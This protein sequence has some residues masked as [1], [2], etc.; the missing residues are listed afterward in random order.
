MSTGS[1]T[2]EQALP[3]LAAAHEAGK[4]VPFVGAGMSME[5][6]KG[7][8][9][10]VEALAAELKLPLPAAKDGQQAISPEDLYRTAD[11][12]ASHL[13]LMSWSARR[14]ILS[15]ALRCTGNTIPKQMAALTGLDWPLI[16]TTNYDDLI[17]KSRPNQHGV[18]EPMVLGRSRK[19][20]VDVVRSLDGLQ[21]PIVWHVQGHIARMA[22]PDAE[23]LSPELLELLEQVVLG[24][25]EYQQA[26][27]AE[28]DFRRAFAEVFRRRSLL[29]LGSGLAE[30]YMV[31]LISEAM[32]GMG[33]SPHPHYAMMTSAEAAK[34]DPAFLAVRLGI[35]P[36]VYGE[37]HGE[38]PE[39]IR[40]LVTDAAAR[41][42]TLGSAQEAPLPP[43][44][45][46]MAFVLDHVDGGQ[47]EVWLHRGG[48]PAAVVMPGQC[49]IL[50]LGLDRAQTGGLFTRIAF[51]NQVRAFKANNEAFGD[52]AQSD[53]V[54][55][56]QQA[57]VGQAPHRLFQLRREGLLKPIF[58]ASTTV[59]CYPAWK[60]DPV[61]GV[62]GVQK[63]PL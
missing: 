43:G 45:R 59:A 20:C 12:A 28:P 6:C 46:S 29:F 62:I 14:R 55:I 54:G 21:R 30:S 8:R 9:P 44:L 16:V 41:K 57:Q 58:G 11:R 4:L 52:I 26:I 51:G 37:N 32:H 17:L 10:F 47:V 18:P 7:W 3:W 13:R 39:A 56:D 36:I 42:P 63:G 34:A 49:V 40:R 31:N 27:N 5:Y 2:F 19:D 22:E 60:K 50:S 1:V 25:Q 38:L 24:H 35:T 15:R 23:N 33:P 53:F 48:L 61:S